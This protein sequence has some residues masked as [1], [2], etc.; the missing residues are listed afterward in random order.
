[1]P[2]TYGDPKGEVRIPKPE[3]IPSIDLEV[4]N[5]HVAPLGTFHAKFA[6]FD[7]QIAI[8]QSNNIQDNDNLEMMT[9]FEGN[10]V[11]SLYDMALITWHNRMQPA[12]PLLNRPATSTMTPTFAQTDFRNMFGEHNHLLSG[13]SGV[14]PT[15]NGTSIVAHPSDIAKRATREDLPLHTSADPHYDENIAKEVLRAA[16]GFVPRDGKPLID[17]INNLLNVPTG[18]APPTAPD[19]DPSQMMTPIIPIPVHEPFSCAMVNR[20]P[21]APPT[22]SSLHTPQ[23]V[24]FQSALRNAAKS[25]FIQTPNLNAAALLPEILAAC[26]RGVEVTYFYCLG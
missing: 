25:V 26:R 15:T 23:N 5:Y 13:F 16:A 2:K 14:Q 1:M 22:S 11:N 20:T 17:G 10:F 24:A 21:F 9:Q 4:V 3:E 7:R 18:G 8:L 6:I 12:L 19:I